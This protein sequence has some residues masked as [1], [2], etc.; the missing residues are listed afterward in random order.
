VDKGVQLSLSGGT[1][2][3]Y[4]F[5][6]KALGE[7]NSGVIIDSSGDPYLKILTYKN[8]STKTTLLADKDEFYLQSYNYVPGSSGIKFDLE[9]GTLEGYDFSFKALNSSGSGVIIDSKT[10][11]YF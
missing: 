2:V 11:P 7:N 3:G 5:S 10:S 1:L 8:G 4:D 6:L 9:N